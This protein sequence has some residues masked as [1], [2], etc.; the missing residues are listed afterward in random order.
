MKGT[1]DKDGNPVYFEDMTGYSQ[2]TY[3][4]K[5]SY[6]GVTNVVTGIVR[7]KQKEFKPSNGNNKDQ[8]TGKNALS[9]TGE[10]TLYGH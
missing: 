1:I 8:N 9:Q 7:D 3:E 2:G 5:Y 6:D 4:V 10:Q